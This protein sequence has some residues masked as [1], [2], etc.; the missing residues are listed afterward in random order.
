MRLQRMTLDLGDEPVLVLGTGLEAAI[1]LKHLLH[2]S[3]PTLE[4]RL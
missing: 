3:A 2:D 1:A 4:K